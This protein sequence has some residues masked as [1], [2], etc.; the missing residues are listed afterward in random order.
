MRR[1]ENI[2]RHSSSCSGRSGG[3][4]QTCHR[5]KSTVARLRAC[6]QKANQ[7][8][9]PWVQAAADVV[10]GSAALFLR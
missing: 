2:A 4:E 3:T 1:E 6:V 8:R 9:G 10:I 5:L 7:T